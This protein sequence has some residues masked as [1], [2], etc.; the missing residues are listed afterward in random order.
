M[1]RIIH[2]IILPR[3]NVL[4]ALLQARRTAISLVMKQNNISQHFTTSVQVGDH[5]ISCIDDNGLSWEH[6]SNRL[7]EIQSLPWPIL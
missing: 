1:I 7:I 4:C 3:K 5:I 2:P 6:N